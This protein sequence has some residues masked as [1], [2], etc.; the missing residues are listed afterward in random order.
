[1][2]LHCDESTSVRCLQANTPKLEASVFHGP[3]RI[4]GREFQILSS[5]VR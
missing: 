5:P 3:H 4:T 1:M 2:S